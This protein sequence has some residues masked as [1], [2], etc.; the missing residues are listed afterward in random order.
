MRP[1]TGE[2][3]GRVS[4]HDVIPLAL[5][6]AAAGGCGNRRPAVFLYRVGVRERGVTRPLGLPGDCP[7]C[8]S[9]MDD[10]L[11]FMP[12]VAAAAGV[13]SGPQRRRSG[14]PKLP[15][16]GELRGDRKLCSAAQQHRNNTRSPQQHTVTAQQRAV[17][18]HYT[19]TR[20]I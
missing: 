8:T 15:G 20:R 6:A 2:K 14:V 18:A 9:S 16:T 1:S 17:I 19:T 3:C 11:R 5:F 4:Q 10:H 12:D 7:P 13:L